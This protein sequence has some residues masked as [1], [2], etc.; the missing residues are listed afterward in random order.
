MWAKMG[1][2]V[3]IEGASRH[4]IVSSRSWGPCPIGRV[5]V[6]ARGW[7]RGGTGLAGQRGASGTVMSM[8]RPSSSVGPGVA[9]GTA[10]SGTCISAA[11]RPRRATAALQATPARLRARHVNHSPVI[12]LKLDR[13]AGH[14][15]RALHFNGFGVAAGRVLSG[16]AAAAARPRVRGH[17][18]AVARAAPGHRHVQGHRRPAGTRASRRAQRPRA[19]NL[20][21]SGRGRG[22][23]GRRREAAAVRRR[24]AAAEA[25]A[26]PHV[27]W[28]PGRY[29]RRRAAGKGPAVASSKGK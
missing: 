17:L 11:A 6:G 25:S 24:A 7:Q 21:H 8:V 18:Q 15:A 16:T 29:G 2:P 5:A 14:R 3:D 10:P 22:R 20:R 9:P 26:S 13:R 19:L 4:L 27:S 28:P 12:Q 23:R 1:L